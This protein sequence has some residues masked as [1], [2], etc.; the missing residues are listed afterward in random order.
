VLH[1][2]EGQDVRDIAGRNGVVVR[3][4][5]DIVIC[6]AHPKGH[7]GAVIGMKRQRLKPLLCKEFQGSAPGR[8]VDMQIRFLF[9]PPPGDGPEVF[10]IL[11]VS[12]VEQIPFYVLKW[13]LDFTLRFR[14]ALSTRNR[15]AV[16]MGDKRGERGIEDRSAAF[17]SKHHGLLTIIETFFGTPP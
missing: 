10:D 4:K 8:I 5:L 14:P 9:E 3:L 11:E 6:S 16:I 12:S 2:F 17:P 13:G 15:F 7:F 1:G